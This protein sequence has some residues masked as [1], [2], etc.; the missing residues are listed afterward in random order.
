MIKIEK[1]LNNIRVN[2]DKHIR[3]RE[4]RAI[5]IRIMMAA[6]G[7]AIIYFGL[8]QDFGFA[9]GITRI[10]IAIVVIII[11]AFLIYRGRYY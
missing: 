2:T 6:I 11:G 3:R 1:D 10:I 9:K 8:T 4:M 5:D 7:G